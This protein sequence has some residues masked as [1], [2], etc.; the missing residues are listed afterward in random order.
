MILEIGSWLGF[1]FGVFFL[2]KV[3][4]ICGNNIY[5]IKLIF[6]LLFLKKVLVQKCADA[7]VLEE[8]YIVPG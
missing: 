2:G 4:Y 7:E 1:G 3:I 5:K 6:F 8:K